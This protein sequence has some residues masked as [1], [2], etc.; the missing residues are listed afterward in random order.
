MKYPAFHSGNLAVYTAALMFAAA[1]F[2]DQIEM[3]N[4]DRYVGRVLSMSTN[5]VMM[6][7]EVLG[8]VKLPRSKIARVTVGDAAADTA[9][10]P[11]G[12][13]NSPLRTAASSLKANSNVVQQVQE[14]YLAEASPEAK[15]KY[16]QL[17]GGLLSGK[18]SVNDIRVE[19]K[20]AAEQLRKLKADLGNDAGEEVDGYLAILESFLSET[21]SS[22]DSATNAPAVSLK[23]KAALA[24]DEK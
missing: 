15:A 5:E 7:N 18:L 1:A 19:A 24:D 3:H 13:T 9:Q 23:T 2:A 12:V 11:P 16:N 22:G 21:K 10:K 20:S 6:Q 4:G 8:T 17:A 14:Q